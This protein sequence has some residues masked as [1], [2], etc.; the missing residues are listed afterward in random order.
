[1]KFNIHQYTI[2]IIILNP[3]LYSCM[4]IRTQYTEIVS[5]NY[6]PRQ[7]ESS[8]NYWL[9][10]V[11]YILY[12]SLLSTAAGE[13]WETWNDILLAFGVIC[14]NLKTKRIGCGCVMRLFWYQ[15]KVRKL[16]YF[17]LNGIERKLF[18]LDR[19]LRMNGFTIG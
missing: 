6:K 5:L 3:Y 8:T 2:I 13:I 9:M 11:I 1:M 14:L 10:S 4:L 15:Q 19:N 18:Y 7:K 12:F 16:F 17:W